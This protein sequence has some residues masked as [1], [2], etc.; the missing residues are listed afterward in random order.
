MGLDPDQWPLILDLDSIFKRFGEAVATQC[1][2]SLTISKQKDMEDAPFCKLTLRYATKA[3]LQAMEIVPMDAT[4]A[5]F[6]VMEIAPLD[7][8]PAGDRDD[9]EI[10]PV[11]VPPAGSRI[12]ERELSVPSD[13]MSTEGEDQITPAD[14]VRLARER[15]RR[16]REELH[17]A[18]EE[19]E[20]AENEIGVSRKRRYS[21]E[22]T[23]DGPA[24]RR[25]R[26]S[27]QAS[28]AALDDE[29]G[30]IDLTGDD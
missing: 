18:E 16:A 13:R 15:V 21:R 3:V 26:L 14:R 9:L 8:P 5:G 22:D 29:G 20:L 24:S 27:S 10:V 25:R 17:R 7:V 30:L 2:R 4:Y 11:D 6:Q 28:R 19:L 1:T 23:E 12:I